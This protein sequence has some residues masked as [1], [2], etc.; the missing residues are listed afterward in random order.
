M[1]EVEI[2][3]LNNIKSPK[4]LVSLDD[5]QLKQLANELRY[6]VIESVSKTGGHLGASLG[7]IELTVALHKIFNAPE[8]KIIWDVGHQTYPHKILTGRRDKMHTLR[9]KDGLSGFTKRDESEFDPFGAG[10]SSTAV[11]AGL[12]MSIGR[13]LKNKN[14]HV[15]CVVGDGA[16]SAGQAYEALNNA[17]AMKSRLI[18]ILNDNDM[19]I[20]PPAGAMSAY[21]AKLISGGTYLGLRNFAKQ[22]VE[23]LPKTL[24][25]GAKK[26]EEITRLIAGNGTLF[27]ALGFYYV[28]PIDGH[29]L[30][31]LLPVIRNVK[32]ADHGPVIIHTVTQKGKGYKPAEDSDEKFHGVAKFNIA[33]GVQ[34]KPKKSNDSYTKVFSEA[35]V[36]CA[37]KDDDI[38]A[39]TAA[40]PSGTGLNKFKEFYPERFFDVGIAEQHAVTFSA[41][42]AIE[43]LKPFAAIYSTFLQRSYDQIVHDVAIQNLPVKFAIDRAG[44]VGADGPTHSGSFDITYLSIL[45]N[46]VVMAASDEVELARMVKTA[47]EYNDGPISFRYPR[48]ESKGL[49]IPEELK[50]IKIGK[51]KIKKEGDK[52][53]FLNLGTRIDEINKASVKL[54][55]MGLSCTIADARFA[56]PL[57][58][59]LII[60]LVKNHELILTIEEGSSGG[61][62]AHV[63]MFLAENG[64]LDD[65]LKIRN[66]YLPDVFIQHG[67]MNNMYEQAGLGSD[68]IVKTVL[69]ALGVNDSE[70]KIIKS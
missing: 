7:V 28:G 19:S 43:G 24:E 1:N 70:F 61:F 18:V 51:G 25:K 26:A 2:K 5:K 67:D 33:T 59:E 54:E 40:M 22:V 36:K 65:G 30:D 27:E 10:H 3:Y 4:D 44:L 41:G 49:L 68:N 47:S 48:G 14:N 57:D 53:A 16:M 20:A 12:G 23:K 13:D 38:V 32:N 63:L 8:D 15:I 9:K 37:E 62:G 52:I 6:D 45:P 58:K 46:F 11:S 42:L 31:H 29:N 34:E 69:S 56:K 50:S 35:L 64:Y 66:L 17:G 60:D 39:V 55:S 21:L